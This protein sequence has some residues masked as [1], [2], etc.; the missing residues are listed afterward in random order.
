MKGHRLAKKCDLE[1]LSLK[2]EIPILF[3]W[4]RLTRKQCVSWS[5]LSKAF[6]ER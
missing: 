4:K 5:V 1:M 3:S 6:K 2:I